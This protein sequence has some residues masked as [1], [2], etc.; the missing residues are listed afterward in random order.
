MTPAKHLTLTLPSIA[1]VCLAVVFSAF[2]APVVISVPAD[3]LA[4]RKALIQSEQRIQTGGTSQTLNPLER[5]V[6]KL[7]MTEKK[8]IIEAARLNGSDFFVRHNFLNVSARAAMEATKAFQILKKMP[9]G[10]HFRFT[11]QILKKM[12]KGNHF[13][14]TFQILTKMPKG[15]HFRFHYILLHVTGYWEPYK[16]PICWIV[17]VTRFVGL[18]R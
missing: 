14:F 12:P 5:L 4:K 6:D 7:L 13:M 11:F 15:N 1:V 9:K 10:N 18:Y 2:F 17:Q 8:K 16:D 3:Y